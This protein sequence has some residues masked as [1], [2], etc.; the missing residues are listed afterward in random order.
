M[1][2]EARY[3]LTAHVGLLSPPGKASELCGRAVPGDSIVMQFATSRGSRRILSFTRVGSSP[4][5]SRVWEFLV[6]SERFAGLGA[7]QSVQ[8]CIRAASPMPAPMP[9]SSD[10]SYEASSDDASS[11]MSALRK[12]QLSHSSAKLRDA[13][14]AMPAPGCQ[15]RYASSLR[16]TMPAP[17]C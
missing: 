9:V 6:K 1:W 10:V 13:S 17:R 2:R 12:C 11:V 16:S 14:S 7:M 3:K 8:Q 4:H 15:L 5:I